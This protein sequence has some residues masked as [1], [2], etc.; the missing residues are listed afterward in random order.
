MPKFKL[1]KRTADIEVEN[2]E[3]KLTNLEVEVD[4]AD[5]ETSYLDDPID[6]IA[7]GLVEALKKPTIVRITDTYRLQPEKE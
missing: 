5:R 7:K 3:A 4:K 6:K 2:T 1:V